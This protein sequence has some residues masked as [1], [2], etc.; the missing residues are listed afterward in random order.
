MR[1][2]IECFRQEQGRLQEECGRLR[3][4]NVL[5]ATLA[6][7]QEDLLK[8]ARMELAGLFSEHEAL[9][10]EYERVTGQSLLGSRT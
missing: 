4:Q 5:L 8:R 2:T 6:E 3:L 1:P 10:A 7:R 9:K